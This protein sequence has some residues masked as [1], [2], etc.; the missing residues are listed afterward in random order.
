MI[1]RPVISKQDREQTLVDLPDICYPFGAFML[2][3]G[4]LDRKSKFHKRAFMHKIIASALT[5]MKCTPLHK[6]LF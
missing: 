3:I 5:F 2:Q 6:T 4:K 1:M